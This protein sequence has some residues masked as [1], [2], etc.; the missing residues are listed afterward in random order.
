MMSERT[1]WDRLLLIPIGVAKISLYGILGSLFLGNQKD[2]TLLAMKLKLSYEST[3]LE[4]RC[5]D[6]NPIKNALKP[7]EQ[8]QRVFLRKSPS[9]C[10]QCFV[11]RSSLKNRSTLF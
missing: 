3:L 2:I 6:E 5:V 8:R 4:A 11:R 7:R 1:D 10:C 9:P